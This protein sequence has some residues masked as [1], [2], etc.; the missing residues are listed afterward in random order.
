M[1]VLHLKVTAGLPVWATGSRRWKPELPR[2][3]V[4]FPSSPNATGITFPELAGSVSESV[5]LNDGGG[6]QPRKE[7]LLQTQTGNGIKERPN[8]SV[9]SMDT[10]NTPKGASPII[11]DQAVSVISKANNADRVKTEEEQQHVTLIKVQR[12]H[13]QSPR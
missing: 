2:V 13:V 1:H 3:T 12:F 6:E 5:L 9:S 10:L 11:K 7:P 4:H 8:I